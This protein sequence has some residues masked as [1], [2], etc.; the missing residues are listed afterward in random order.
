LHVDAAEAIAR[1][2]FLAA[3]DIFNRMGSLPNEAWARQRAAARPI[4]S[5]GG[6]DAH[7]QLNAALRFW[8]L[9]AAT[10]Y[11]RESEALFADTA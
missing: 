6:P 7:E 11:I 8:R 4:D 9:V 1:G 3:A 2:D 10:R 5:K